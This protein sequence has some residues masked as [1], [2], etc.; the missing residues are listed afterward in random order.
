MQRSQSS[1][2]LLEYVGVEVQL[3]VTN[4]ARAQQT[5]TRDETTRDFTRLSW[6]SWKVCG[7]GSVS[8]FRTNWLQSTLLFRRL[9]WACLG[10]NHFMG[11]HVP[12]YRIM[13]LTL[14]PWALIDDR[15]QS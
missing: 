15:H 5:R 14:S 4:C 6:T 2:V 1:K 9:A 12:E 11:G 13:D 8:G 3:K 10:A 7:D